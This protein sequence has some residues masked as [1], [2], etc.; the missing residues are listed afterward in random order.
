MLAGDPQRVGNESPWHRAKLHLTTIS[1]T[2]RSGGMPQEL[3]L[4]KH[5]SVC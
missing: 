5:P 4:K 2:F 3:A 1:G